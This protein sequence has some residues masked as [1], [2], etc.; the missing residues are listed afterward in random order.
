MSWHLKLNSGRIASVVLL[1]IY[2][3]ISVVTVAIVNLEMRREALVEAEAKAR[4]IL[5]RNLAIH[6]Y[7]SH[8]LKPRL[9]E[10]TAPFRSPE[11]FDPAWMSSTYAVR[12]IEA[13]FKSLNSIGYYYKECALSARSPENEADEFE[14]AF[15]DRINQDPAV[16]FWSG[17]RLVNGTPSFVILRQ[18][19]ILEDSCLRCHSEPSRAP[20]DMIKLY[21][22]ERSFHR[23]VGEVASAISM[24][25]PLS[26]AYAAANSFS[27]RLS[28]ILLA[29]VG[30]LLMVLQWANARYIYR[31]LSQIRRKAMEI[32]TSDAHLGEELPLAHGKD[33]SELT[34]AFNEMS[35]NL[36]RHKDHLEALV[37]DRTRALEIANR[38]LRDSNY[39]YRLLAESINDVIAI[40]DLKGTFLYLSPSVEK[41]TGW[42]PQEGLCLNGLEVAH[43]D[44]LEAVRQSYEIQRPER[45]D[46]ILQWRCCCKDASYVW[47][48]TNAHL[49]VDETG[50]PQHFV[51][52]SR[53]ITTRKRMQEALQ[54]SEEKFSRVFH[55]SPAPISIS[56]LD[57]GC[58]IEVNEAFSAVTGYSRPEAIGHSSVELGLFRSESQRVALMQQLQETG[59]LHGVELQ[60]PDR[61]GRPVTL[62]WSAEPITVEGKRCIVCI[63]IDITE[64]KR[65]EDERASL[66]GRLRQAQKL[67]AIGT[68]AGG[69]AHDF[70][71]ILGIIMGYAEISRMTM[72][73]DSAAHESIAEVLKATERARDLVKQILTFSRQSDQ[74]KKPLQATL[75]VK[76]VVKMLRA[77]LPTTIE[78]R[79]EIRTSATEDVILADPT[80]IHQLVMNLCTNAGHA[81]R[82]KGGVLAI[83]A[84]KLRL[85]AETPAPGL[86][87]PPGDY[88][89]LT[90][91]DT[92]HGIDPALLDRIFDPYFTTKGPGEGTGLGLAVVHGIVESCRGAVAV[93]SEPGVGTTFRVYLPTLAKQCAAA[94]RGVES[95]QGGTERILLVDD[96]E[97]LVRAGKKMLETLGYR[98]TEALGSVQ[99]LEVFRH[100]PAAFDLVITDY[101]M[102]HMTGTNLARELLTL[103][104]DLPVILC[105]GRPDGINEAEARAAGIR[106]L[107][108]KPLTRTALAQSVRRVLD[109]EEGRL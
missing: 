103:R 28:V 2:L 64:R 67:E 63:G 9:F 96:E 95:L 21:G 51:S 76:E 29:A 35:R 37:A 43:P 36:R 69:I 90:V 6:T 104:P 102:P 75:I 13:H 82:E 60:I 73:H 68:L 50:E 30:I 22:A 100:Q 42:S 3:M 55:A 10:W 88:L 4:M 87:L 58:F 41:V 24:R 57:T 92:G 70:N 72:P 17:V 7:F 83:T 56:E 62:L 38:Q 59:R 81:M 14:R 26:E 85:E 65:A 66:E 93:T 31:P 74:E 27:F 79:L 98:V 109:E 44:D 34:R 78:I 54:A 47:L 106:E 86:K 20:A 19:E 91:S 18:G 84:A 101:T 105:T 94:E 61:A 8:D 48:E 108:M 23:Q 32:A 39:Q 40:T 77:A 107:I 99:A 53:D 16:A 5:D 52:S 89:Q 45:A 80:E 46:R 15:L 49:V 71:N 97:G 1:A 33:L 25:I 12:K 11:Y